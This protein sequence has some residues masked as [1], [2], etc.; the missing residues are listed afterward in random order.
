MDAMSVVLLVASLLLV[1]A[2]LAKAV[3]PGDTWR[4]LSRAGLPVGRG[5]ATVRVGASVE[6][7]IGVTAILVG[8]PVPGAM[9]CLSYVA[10]AVF[11]SVALGRGWA[12]A[13][14]GCFGEPDSPP[15]VAHVVLDAVLAAGSALAAVDGV[16]PRDAVTRHPGT[17]V[18]TLSM[19]LVTTGLL[20]LVFARLPRLRVSPAS[21]GGRP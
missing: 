18:V 19:A 21:S 11:I 3:R 16:S 17:G 8:G 13:S 12:L 4:A 14:C 20:Y 1:G 7:A 6:V 9:V 2:G 15:T 10:F 5:P